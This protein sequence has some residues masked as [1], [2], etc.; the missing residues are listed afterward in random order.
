MPVSGDYE[1]LFHL[2][3]QASQADPI[4]LVKGGTYSSLG[5]VGVPSVTT[6]KLSGYTI[7]DLS[8]QGTETKQPVTH[9]IVHLNQ[10]DVISIINLATSGNGVKLKSSVAG[11]ILAGITIKLLRED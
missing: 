7:F 1:I 4:A 2:T 5:S 11:G 6:G 9:G 8:P 10:D 3:L